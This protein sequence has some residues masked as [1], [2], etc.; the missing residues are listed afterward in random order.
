MKI[1]LTDGNLARGSPCRT[2][3]DNGNTL[4]PM[5]GRDWPFK[6]IL[7]ART[8]SWIHSWDPCQTCIEQFGLYM[9]QHEKQRSMVEW[10][11]PSWHRRKISYQ[12]Q[13]SEL[14]DTCYAQTSSMPCILPRLW[15]RPNWSLWQIGVSRVA[16]T[17]IAFLHLLALFNNKKWGV[18]LLKKKIKILGGIFHPSATHATLTQSCW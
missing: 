2:V 8:W 11:W 10:F 3:E 4:A 1:T 16:R 12:P 5:P 9:C 13:I 18:K 6:G 15:P 7:F 17:Q 14:Q